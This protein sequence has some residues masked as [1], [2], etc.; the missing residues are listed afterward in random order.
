[1]SLIRGKQA[2]HKR[3]LGFRLIEDAIDMNWAFELKSLFIVV[4]FVV[5]VVSDRIFD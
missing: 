4:A 3:I 2:T 5:S 1:M